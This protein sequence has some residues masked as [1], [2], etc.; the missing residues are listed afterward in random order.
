VCEREPGCGGRCGPNDT[1]RAPAPAPALASERE[2]VVWGL[3]PAS[4]IGAPDVVGA[5]RFRFGLGPGLLA[6]FAPV[7]GAAAAPGPAPEVEAGPVRAGTVGAVVAA[8]AAAAA[9]AVAAAAA[10]L[11]FLRA[12]GVDGCFAE[13]ALPTTPVVLAGTPLAPAAAPAAGAPA[14]TP[15]A[16]DTAGHAPSPPAGTGEDAT[17]SAKDDG[18]GSF[19]GSGTATHLERCWAKRDELRPRWQRGQRTSVRQQANEK[20]AGEKRVRGAQ[21][22]NIHG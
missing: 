12:F 13:P 16:A 21:T 11:L 19:G 9:A 17:A 10:A 1:A 5:A 7:P 15:L 6:V 3:L 2:W 4:S 18:G 20:E 8:A 14:E 22:Q